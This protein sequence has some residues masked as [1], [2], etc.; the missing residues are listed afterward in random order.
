MNGRW[1]SRRCWRAH[2]AQ[3][4]PQVPVATRTEAVRRFTRPQ[5][6]DLLRRKM[7]FHLRL[8]KGEEFSVE[9]GDGSKEHFH[10][11][12]VAWDEP[13]A[14]TFEVVDQLTITS[15]NT[16]RPDIVV[17]L[18]GM[19][20]VVFELKSPWSEYADVAG[21]LNQ[22]GHCTHDIAQLSETNALY[23]V[24]DGIS[25]LHG[26]WP[27]GLE[28]YT[29]WKITDGSKVVPGTTGSMT[30][31][32]EGLFPKERLLTCVRDFVLYENAHEKITKK[33]AKYHQFFAA[34]IAAEQA[35]KAMR[36]NRP[37][38]RLG[39]IWHTRGSSMPP[40][41]SAPWCRCAKTLTPLRTAQRS[42]AQAKQ[43]SPST[44]PCRH[45]RPRL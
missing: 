34:R 40:P 29:P 23:V 15:Q 30:M 16:R 44:L 18:S 27:G 42:S 13:K 1:F 8:V 10:L 36:D 7:D 26:M 28:W 14:N 17:Y 21:A 32:I 20:L 31:L 19:P 33:G 11:H 39:V 37:D 3:R 41:S 12:A 2:L 6:V 45:A 9:R 5:G 25:T 43:N 35:V 22:I 38:K 24:S 4:Y